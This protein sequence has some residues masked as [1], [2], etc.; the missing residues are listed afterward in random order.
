V[1][2][3]ALGARA[4][5]WAATYAVHST[6]LLGFVAVTTHRLVR[7]DSWR[8]VLWRGA[9][10]GSV[11]TATL[12]TAL[13]LEP[14]AGRW[15]V[16]QIGSP[17][18]TET[19]ARPA[20]GARDGDAGARASADR[21]SAEDGRDFPREPVV[22]PADT[23]PLFTAWL[24][25][26][27]AAIAALL[28][29]LLAGRN[30]RVV[31]RLRGR[32]R[33][34][35]G[36]LVA[37]LAELR[38][39]GGVWSPVR[40]SVSPAAPTPLVIGA[41][42]ICLP[43]R[44]LDELAEDEQ[45]AALAHELAH[46]ARKDPWWQLGIALL[47][48]LLFFQPLHNLARRRLRDA[49]ENLCDDW[50]VRQTGSPLALGRCLADIAS[51]VSTDPLPHLGST[52]AM[53]EGGS[54]LLERVRRI[55]D[56][57]AGAPAPRA[58]PAAAT[59]ALLAVTLA[60]APA[61]TGARAGSAEPAGELA[62][63]WEEAL[64]AGGEAG[65]WVGWGIARP[66]GAG[67][68]MVISSTPGP[69]GR[70]GPPLAEVLRAAGVDEVPQIAF[71]FGFDS[72]GRGAGDVDWM[73]IRSAD[74]PADLGGLPLRWLGTPSQEESLAQ[75]AWL[76]GRT[77]LA[78]VQAEL[79]AALTLHAPGSE[80][81]D[82]IA[83]AI[84]AAPDEEVRAEVADWLANQDTPADVALLERLAMEDPSPEVRQEAASDLAEFTDPAAVS[85]LLR[86]ARAAPDPRVRSEAVQRLD[87]SRSDEVVAILMSMVF[88]DPV[89]A[90]RLDAV[91]VL[92][93]MP[94]AAARAALRRIASDHSDGLVRQA[95]IQALPT[96]D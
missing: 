73:M 18:S 81:H 43:P 90:V 94:T 80:T 38:R 29:A 7:S 9:I 91:D 15:S 35:G 47:H 85:A 49:A 21:A 89:A 93:G 66:A 41:S 13:P 68:G 26:G 14:L 42:E 23:S 72:K 88:E 61:V 62:E 16:P 55:V 65:F 71:L 10:L 76:Y 70:D 58:L 31:R 6:L 83:A 24:F 4:I 32:E 5:E 40:L 67:P 77:P 46:V 12:A 64:A 75:L 69:A 39:L 63:R 25:L 36:R 27:W 44:F 87:E 51:W 20:A 84:A 17:A 92:A 33:V 86:L 78:E 57:T 19:V 8:E 11:A 54:P 45:R 37:M 28:L 50:A 96:D 59:A 53:A 2:L 1:T 95:A 60:L 52:H 3:E 82:A 56:G 74:A 48:A 30:V 34:V 22:F 79:V